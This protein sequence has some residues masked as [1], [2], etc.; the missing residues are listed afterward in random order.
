MTSAMPDRTS[1]ESAVALACRAPSLHNSQPWRWVVGRFGLSLFSDPDRLLPA[2]D[3]FGR[4]MVISCGA[5]L[6]HLEVAFA[7]QGWDI[8]IDRS[9]PEQTVSSSPR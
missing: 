8:E 9:R 6:N 3:D 4:Q 7:A 5:A 1:L 2:T